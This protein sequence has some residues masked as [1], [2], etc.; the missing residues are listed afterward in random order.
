MKARPPE[1]DGTANEHGTQGQ[2]ENSDNERRGGLRFGVDRRG[3]AIGRWGIKPPALR[4]DD[5][6]PNRMD[7]NRSLGNAIDP[8]V[9]YEL[10]RAISAT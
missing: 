7:R 1:S 5:E 2:E 8:M 10:L 9:A 3:C 6:L 4:V